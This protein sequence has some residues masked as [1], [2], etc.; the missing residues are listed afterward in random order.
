MSFEEV[1]HKFEAINLDSKV[2][3]SMS[4]NKKLVARLAQIVDLAG[5]KADKT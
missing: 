4:K 1:K 5:G 2:I 3:E